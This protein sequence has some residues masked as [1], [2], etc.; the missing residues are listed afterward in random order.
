[1]GSSFGGSIKLSGE[2]EYKKALKEIDSSLRV[3]GSE[4]KEVTSQ[5]D[6][7]D[8]SAENL[9]KQN[10]VLTKKISEQEAKVETLRKALQASA[11]ETGENSEK[12]KRY[13]IQLN[14][15]QAELNTMNRQLEN[16]KKD[17]A[18]A[19][20]ATED[21]TEAIDDLKD[22]AGK[23]EKAFTALGNGIKAALEVA[24]AATAA[25]S[26]AFVAIGKQAI[27]LYSDYEQLTGGV[28]TLFKDSSGEVQKYAANAYKTAGLSA[29]EYMET[30]TSFSA[31][32]L[33][34]LDGDTSKAAKVADMAISDMSDNANKMGTDMSMI[35][36]AYQGFAKQN[37][38]MLDNLK[39]G[40][41]GT[42]TEM[43][44]LLKD[45]TELS[46]VEYDIDSLSDVYEAIHVI[47]DELDITGTTAKEASTTISGSLSSMKSAWDNLL[48]GVADDSQDFD[49]L[50][51][52]MIESV[53]TFGDNIIPRI[54]TVISGIG[55]LVQGFAE[56]LIPEITAILP[57][58][59]SEL[60]P[61]AI[62]TVEI[63]ISSVVDILP[64]LIELFLTDILPNLVTTVINITKNLISSLATALPDIM[65]SLAEG[66]VTI[67]NTLFSPE[68]IA[69][70]VEILIQVIEGII[71]GIQEALPILIEGVFTLIQ[72]LVEALPD[73]ITTIVEAIPGLIT[74]LVDVI[75]ENL[76]LLID[77]VIAL[78]DGIVVA[79]PEIIKAIISAL[80]DI[81]SA[82]VNAIVECLPA[83]IQG[84]IDLILGLVQALPQLITS[85][86]DALPDLISTIIDAVVTNLP[87]LI[88]GAIDL[89]VGL[90]E[91]LPDIIVALIEALPDIITSIVDALIECLPQ[92]IEGAITLVIELVKH[93][94]EIILALIEAI[95]TI[96][97]SIV[98]AFGP[99]V[100]GMLEVG[101]NLISGLWEGICNAASWLW[102]QISGWLGDLWDGI[103]G[104]FGIHSPSTKMRDMVGKNIVKGLAEGITD[105]GETAVKA[106]EDL[107]KEIADVDFA[108]GAF[109]T[110]ELTDQLQASM[111]TLEAEAA[112]NASLADAIGLAGAAGGNV[113]PV[114]V[115][116][117]FGDVQLA[118]DMDIY[119][120]ADQISD[121]I[122][123][124]VVRVGGR[125]G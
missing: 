59:L 81:I 123:A 102:E 76:P 93:L 42:K 60:L 101:G 117:Q 2:S 91:A 71:E 72:G 94:P 4:M 19:E 50:I 109:D 31:S 125:F 43:E 3:L 38:T 7:N 10:E 107:A 108:P 13:Q 66:L 49:M 17:M 41:G 8:R 122:A 61:E 96:I 30:V 83:L 118:S 90:V 111:P 70:T 105:E 112:I 54:E 115:M 34:S 37:Y 33:Q 95:P 52:N 26:A 97:T 14:N 77:G 82:I 121:I 27:E 56:K 20:A 64:G 119:D 92:L 63:L 75:V 120:V 110:S 124:N 89:I 80:P 57:D 5:F 40:Y 9:S 86:V 55:K 11:E 113:S 25:V 99:L 48:I 16:N 21:E 22:E 29:N 46:G 36:S 116:I 24:A 87:I 47:Q 23:T 79:L 88:Q 85:I 103:L 74:S 45:A 51:D 53:L 98:E 15:A 78:I 65:K 44:R 62:S 1:M 18:A 32:L 28:E 84:A 104:F 68:N 69:E 106:T 114:N 6:K 12:T 67:V 73:I 35:Q 100:S 58:L 39:L